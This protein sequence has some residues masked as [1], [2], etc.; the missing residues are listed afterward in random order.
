[1]DSELRAYDDAIVTVTSRGKTASAPVY[2]RE[3]CEIVSAL[4][5]KQG[6]EFKIM[7]QPKW[8]GVQTIQF[9]N[10]LVAVQEL[11]WDVKPTKIIECGVAHGGQ[12]VFLASL[13]ALLGNPEARVIG[14]DI[15]IRE[16]NRRTIESHPLNKFIHLIERS[17][18]H[19]ATIKE[20][21]GLIGSEDRVMVI[22]DSNHTFEHVTQ[23]I[24]KY[25]HLVSVG[26]YLV[27]MDAALGYVGDIPRG[28]QKWFENNPILAIDNLLSL[29]D[30]FILNPIF[31]NF[32]TTSS[33]QGALR[34]IKR[35]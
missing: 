7:Y 24:E 14:V 2:S 5:L 35:T 27:V 10:D 18:L 29:D 3:G 25:K 9:P 4:A 15:E 23:E 21:D 11:V 8:L 30:D 19:E 31:E 28:E 26:S 33:P 13:L 17:S 1:M 16:H 6:A 12:T 32:G 22:L 34:R 20:I